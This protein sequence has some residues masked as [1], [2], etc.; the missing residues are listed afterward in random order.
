MSEVHRNSEK[1]KHFHNGD[2]MKVI[3]SAFKY[4]KYRTFTA[5]IVDIVIQCTADAL[6][7]NLFIYTRGSQ[8]KTMLLSH[9]CETGSDIDIYHKYNWMGGTYHGADHYTPLVLLPGM[10]STTLTTNPQRNS[11]GKCTIL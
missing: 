8:G 2:V 4:L 7:I 11:T 9:L 6:K 1:F 10:I 3:V 5:N